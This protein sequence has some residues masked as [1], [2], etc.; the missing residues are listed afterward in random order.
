MSNAEEKD[1]ISP[2]RDNL[3]A[4]RAKVI[5]RVGKALSHPLRV[6]IIWC[7]AHQPGGAA[8]VARLIG[9]SLSDV[10]YHLNE[11]LDRQCHMVKQA[12]ERKTRGEKETVY[13]LDSTA[14]PPDIAE[15]ATCLTRRVGIR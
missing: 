8:S 3:D 14:F 4:E 11:V 7:L 15:L 5:A 9:G 2:A 12:R 1:F 13:E 10:S 6:E